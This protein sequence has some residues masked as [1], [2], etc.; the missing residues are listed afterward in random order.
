[1]QFQIMKSTSRTLPAERT[2]YLCFGF[3]YRNFLLVSWSMTT[4]GL[5]TWSNRDRT[6]GRV[7][8]AYASCSPR[9]HAHNNHGSSIDICNT[10]MDIQRIQQLIQVPFLSGH[11]SPLGISQAVRGGSGAQQRHMPGSI[12]S[13]TSNDNGSCNSSRHRAQ[14][15]ERTGSSR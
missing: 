15:Q 9:P 10:Y 14:Q 6:K 11:H 7:N 1:M 2:W 12:T 4:I 8:R 5:L 13:S 3:E